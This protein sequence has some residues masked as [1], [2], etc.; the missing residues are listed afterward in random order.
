MNKMVTVLLATALVVLLVVPASAARFAQILYNDE[1]KCD[2]LHWEFESAEPAQLA[3]PLNRQMDIT[4]H[5]DIVRQMVLVDTSETPVQIRPEYAGKVFSR[6]VTVYVSSYTVDASGTITNFITS[7]QETHTF[8]GID[9]FTLNRKPDSYFMMAISIDVKGK[10]SKLEKII[11]KHRDEVEAGMQTTITQE[12]YVAVLQYKI[13][14]ENYLGSIENP[15]N[16][17]PAP[18]PSELISGIL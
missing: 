4:A 10:I 8:M 15:R 9:D 12:Q 14:L 5:P 1:L 17:P 3:A 7:S 13:A 18:E 11:S 6:E 2:Y 16:P